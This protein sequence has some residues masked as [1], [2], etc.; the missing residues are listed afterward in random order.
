MA[1]LKHEQISA[2][3]V[4]EGCLSVTYVQAGFPADFA[5][6]MRQSPGM[7][8]E[9]SAKIEPEKPTTVIPELNAIEFT[10]FSL[11]G[12]S[13]EDVGE[14]LEQSKK[15]V[16][17][18]V[19]LLEVCDLAVARTALDRVGG[20]LG[21]AIALIAQERCQTSPRQQLPESA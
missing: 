21:A 1:R 4:A 15:S 13:R 16:K 11:T 2:G 20:R 6:A 7:R 3:L 18:A 14:A 12:K 10:P 17:L 9:S 8:R 19:L 5:E